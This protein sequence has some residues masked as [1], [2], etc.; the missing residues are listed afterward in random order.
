MSINPLTYI[1]WLKSELDARGVTFVRK[2]VR[3]IEE[4]ADMAGPNGIVV[5]AS[6]LGMKCLDR[7]LMWLLRTSQ[8]PGLS[9]GC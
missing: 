9:L 8:V 7:I 4:V 3:S 1:P 2:R 5:N 6:S